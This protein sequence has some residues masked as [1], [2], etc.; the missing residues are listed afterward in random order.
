MAKASSLVP[1][2]MDEEVEVSPPLVLTTITL[3]EVAPPLLN[4]AVPERVEPG[5]QS[6]D[7]FTPL[8]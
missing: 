5:H 3:E 6:R 1:Q 2:F 4:E 7:F 8:S